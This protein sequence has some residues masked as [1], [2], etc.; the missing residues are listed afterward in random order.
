MV[1]AMERLRTKFANST[2][3]VLGT[4]VLTYQAVN[5]WTL[6]HTGG[7][8]VSIAP[9]ERIRLFFLE[10]CQGHSKEPVSTATTTVR[11]TRNHY[12]SQ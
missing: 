3:R 1:I 7:G 11:I 12:Q 10:R 5:V 9:T 2:L 4:Y 8:T 6:R